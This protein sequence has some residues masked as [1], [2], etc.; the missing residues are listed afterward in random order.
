[1][2]M[3]VTVMTVIAAAVLGSSGSAARTDPPLALR[4]LDGCRAI[5]APAQRL[6]CFDQT[7]AQLMTATASGEISVVDRAEMRQARRSL[8]GF[9]MPKLP[10]FAGD[11]SAEDD[12]GTL[13]S[14]ITWVR[15]IDDERFQLR[16]A[17]GN[18]LWETVESYMTFDEP[19]KG[20][21]ISIKRGPLGSYVLRINGQ[22]GLKGKRVG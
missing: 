13:D 16:V 9:A 11:R 2:G 18:A 22:R 15:R 3:S 10:F 21:K 14:T 5:A 12:K 6:A 8:F 1:M 4:A 19:R 20:Q 17:D 7:T